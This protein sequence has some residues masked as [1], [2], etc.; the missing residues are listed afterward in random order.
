MAFV[1]NIEEETLSNPAFRNVISTT[2]HM[3]LVLMSLN[4]GEDI[5]AEVHHVDQFIRIER[6]QALAIVAGEKYRLSDGDVI[7]I[8][9]GSHHNIYNV[10]NDQLKMY[11][12]YAPPQHNMG[13]VE[14]R[15][16]NYSRR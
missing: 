2:R 16:P 3:Q 4:P 6:G 5:G 10:D 9:A 13:L 11:S 8:P 1:V 14:M 12:I 15:K 7:I